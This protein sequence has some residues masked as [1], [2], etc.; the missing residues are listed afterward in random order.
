[1]PDNYEAMKILSS[2]FTNSGCPEKMDLAKEYLQ[3]LTERFSDDIEAWIEYA[4]ISETN[5]CAT[6]LTAY[7][8]A[9]K[10]MKELSDM[11]PPEILNNLGVCYYR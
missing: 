6:A 1:M 7:E 8:T 2:L 11:I 3:K 4:Q 10:L 9:L 5:H